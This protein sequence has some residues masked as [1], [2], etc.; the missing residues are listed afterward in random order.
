MSNLLKTVLKLRAMGFKPS[1][2]NLEAITTAL[3]YRP[4]QLPLIAALKDTLAYQG[5]IKAQMEI[6]QQYQKQQANSAVMGAGQ[7]PADS[8]P[9]NLPGAPAPAP[10]APMA[11]PAPSP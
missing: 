3:K 7:M 11:P 6:L 5:K 1:K 9:A 4:N 10:G 8:N 2:A